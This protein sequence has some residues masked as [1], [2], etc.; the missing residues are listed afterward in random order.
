[1]TI[2][3]YTAVYDLWVHTPGMGLNTADDSREGIAK[4]LMRNPSNCFV[5]EDDGV[6]AGAIMAGHDGRRGYIHH[7]AVKSGY[8]GR[9]IAGELVRLAVDALEKEGINKVSLAVYSDN[10]SGNAFWE[11]MGFAER[12]DLVYRSRNIHEPEKI[13]V[14]L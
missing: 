4:Y 5:A 6:I 12:K 9:G 11:H 8:S 13:R 3:D 1:M 10:D 14:L 7:T 2:E